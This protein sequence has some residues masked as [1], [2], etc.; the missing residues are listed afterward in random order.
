MK[1]TFTVILFGL[2]ATAMAFPTARKPNMF[3]A[4]DKSESNTAE[5]SPEVNVG[6]LANVP[7][8]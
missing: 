8:L 4:E 7:Q 3:P 5:R 2:L 1:P 6:L